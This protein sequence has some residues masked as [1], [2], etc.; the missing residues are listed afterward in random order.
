M[1][2]GDHDNERVDYDAELRLLND[3]LREAYDVGPEDRVLDIGCGAGQTTRDAA[4]LASD[5]WALGVDISKEMIERAR[6]LADAEGL[7]NVT[8]EH[9]DAQDHRFPPE[10][11]DLAISRFGTMFFRDPVAAFTNIGTGLRRDG[12]LLIMVWQAHER[13]EWSVAIQ[14]ALSGTGGSPLPTPEGLD[15]FSLADPATVRQILDGAGFT[16]VTLTEVRQPM[17][18]GQDVADALG[19]IG[20]FASTKGVLE[21]L[22]PASREVALERLRETLAANAREDGVWFD[23]RAWIVKARRP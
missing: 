17:Y 8:F 4:R 3:S 22:D 19:W 2:M 18:F 6:R 21:G 13:N 23:S 14:S 11:F 12:R 10:R 5:G 7:H 15:H 20:G 9:A 1:V 16:D